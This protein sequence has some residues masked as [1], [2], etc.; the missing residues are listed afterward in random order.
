MVKIWD[1]RRL[2]VP[3]T[4]FLEG[5]FQNWT[6][7]TAQL[8]GSVMLYLAP[9]TKIAPIRADFER[10]VKANARRDGRVQVAQVTETR[11]DAIELRLLVRAK[12]SP[13]LFDLRCDIREGM[14]KWLADN[15]PEAFRRTA[16]C[17]PVL[18]TG[19][20]PG[21][22]RRWFLDGQTTRHLGGLPGEQHDQSN[23]DTAHDQV[24]NIEM[25]P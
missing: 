25:Q 10:Q 22:L 21:T 13:T 20:V 15:H 4:R 8:L 14:L 11:A 23:P 16:G 17:T 7:K 18:T 12:N 2:I 9:A 3:P 1:E 19:S 6:K 5:A 24:E